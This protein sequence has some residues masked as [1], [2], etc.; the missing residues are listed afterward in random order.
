MSIS[1][2]GAVTIGAFTLPTTDGS[3]GQVLQTN[4]SGTVTWQSAQKT[5]TSGTAAPTGG[6]DG[7]IYLQ[8][9]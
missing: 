6:A 5:I 3:N 2:A 9:V 1:S 8:Y 7:D 4:G